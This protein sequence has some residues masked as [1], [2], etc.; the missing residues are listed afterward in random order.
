MEDASG[1]IARSQTGDKEAREALIEKNLGLVRS[2]VRRFASRGADLED[3]FQIGVIGLIKAID[4]FDLKVGVKFSTYAVPMITG[5]IKR[6]LRD[7]GLV[8]I[9]RSLKE[10]NQKVRIAR[11]RLQ[12]RLGREPT[13]S[14]LARETSLLPE[15]IVMAMEAGREVESLSSSFQQEDGSE[16]S[17]ADRVVQPRP[18]AV[19]CT[20]QASG[21]DYEKEGLLNRILLQELL[22]TLSAG[23]RELIDLR[24]FQGKTQTQT[25]ARL[26]LSQVQVSRQEKRILLRLR[27]LAASESLE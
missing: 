16:I 2:I 27:K 13:L 24:Y 15:D 25:A 4:H 19:D 14:E 12:G 26:G 10:N 3:L 1:L 18:G 11:H 23:E 22:Q 8:R 5:E 21:E 6:F 9:S 17:L 20:L 7:D